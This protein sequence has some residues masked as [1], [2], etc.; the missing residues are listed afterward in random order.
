MLIRMC[1]SCFFETFFVF[2]VTLYTHL[3]EMYV[4]ML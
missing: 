4:N 2:L 1:H 3:V